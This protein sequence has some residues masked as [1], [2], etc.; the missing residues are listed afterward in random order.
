MSVQVAELSVPPKWLQTFG[1]IFRSTFHQGPPEKTLNVTRVQPVLIAG[2]IVTALSHDAYIVASSHNSPIETWLSDESLILRQGAVHT[3]SSDLLPTNGHGPSGLG[4]FYEYRLDMTEPVLQGYARKGSTQ[5]YVTSTD[6]SSGNLSPE[7]EI[8]SGDESR[9]DPEGVEIDECFLASSILH[10]RQ[11]VSLSSPRETVTDRLQYTNVERGEPTT[12]HVEIRFRTEP[13][14]EPSTSRDDCTLYL[15]TSD[16]GRVG[17]LN[18]DWVRSLFPLELSRKFILTCRL[19]FTQAKPQV[20]VLFKYMRG[21]IWCALREIY[22]FGPVGLH[23]KLAYQRHCNG[24][25]TS[26]AQH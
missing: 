22:N 4:R 5:F 8:E 10:S 9:S 1:H 3:F 13:L 16:L 17:I 7:D 11:S 18:G 20:I 21:T 12:S 23:A 25:P 6:H 19:L 24:F 14:P 2:A 15:R 26:S